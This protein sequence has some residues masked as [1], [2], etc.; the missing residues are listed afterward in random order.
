MQGQSSPVRHWSKLLLRVLLILAF[1][2]GS[3]YLVYQTPLKEYLHDIGKVEA[4]LQRTG[5]A[6]PLIFVLA[7]A[8]LVAIGVPRLLL[9][10]IA[11]AVFG[12][13][14]GLFLS[15]LGTMLGSYAC[16]L[17]VRWGGRSFVIRHWPRL[18]HLSKSFQ[19]SGFVAVFLIRQLPIGAVFL[20]IIL[21]LTPVAHRHFLIGTLIGI[22]PEA[23]P[24]TLLGTGA[25]EFLSGRSLW[26]ISIAL[27]I[28]VVIWLLLAEYLKKAKMSSSV[29]ALEE[30][31][32]HED[33]Q[34]GN[35]P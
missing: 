25:T 16:F 11:G 1:A 4:T 23:I 30:E 7:T 12:F 8:I 19:K 9:C 27:A 6:A 17:F 29:A 3:I 14:W 26:K 21:G 5:A 24:A 35:K 33:D 13:A 22:L 20:N 2:V 32:E 31:L 18:E 10:P 34:S 15:Q 28:L